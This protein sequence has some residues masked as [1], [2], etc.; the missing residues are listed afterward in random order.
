MSVIAWKKKCMS[1]NNENEEQTTKF[2][3]Q[4]IKKRNTYIFADNL[5]NF[6][7]VH[8]K[9]TGYIDEYVYH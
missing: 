4:Y 7:D 2:Y 1:P 6:E 8:F 5:S 9:L 3:T